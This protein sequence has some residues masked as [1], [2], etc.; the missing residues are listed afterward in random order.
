M[1]ILAFVRERKKR[2]PSRQ[3]LTDDHTTLKEAAVPQCVL[4]VLK[5]KIMTDTG[6]TEPTIWGVCLDG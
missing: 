5:L 4:P 1:W 2:F 3:L 6:V